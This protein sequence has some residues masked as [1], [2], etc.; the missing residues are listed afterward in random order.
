MP[1]TELSSLVEDYLKSPAIFIFN[2]TPVSLT[3]RIF[4]RA[5]SCQNAWFV[6][7]NQEGYA[8]GRRNIGPQY[9]FFACCYCSV[10]MEAYFLN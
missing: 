9:W 2:D 8:T 5:I 1:D 4:L 3:G 7:T 6:S 10:T